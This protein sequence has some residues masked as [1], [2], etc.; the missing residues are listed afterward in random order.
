MGA[1]LI[2]RSF[3]SGKQ[4]ADVHY[5]G[6]FPMKQEPKINQTNSMGELR[7]LPG[8]YIVDG[9]SLSALSEKPHTFTI[10]ANADR[11]GKRVAQLFN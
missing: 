5:A 6:T 3:K 7:A 1:L 4:G 9:A 2:P 8:M 11:I 10:M